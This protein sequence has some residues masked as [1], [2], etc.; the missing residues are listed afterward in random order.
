[1]EKRSPILLTERRDH[2]DYLA[3]HLHG[4]ARNLIVLHGGMKAKDRRAAIRA[5]HE[6][7]GKRG[8]PRPGNR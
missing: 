8:T 3:K 1:M 2:L 4:P 6:Y 5:T 7:P